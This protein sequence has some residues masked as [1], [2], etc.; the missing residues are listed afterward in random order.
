MPPRRS[1]WLP[2]GLRASR[3]ST[4]ASAWFLLRVP[5]TRAMSSSS[6]GVQARPV[7]VLV[8][9]AVPPP[10]ARGARHQLGGKDDAARGSTGPL[11]GVE[12]QVN[13]LAS[14]LLDGLPDAGEGGPRGGGDVGVLERREDHGVV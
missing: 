12:Q 10:R 11:D 8:L 5:G 2:Q 13:A 3:G 14:Q 4:G 9:S 7:A 1:R 6:A